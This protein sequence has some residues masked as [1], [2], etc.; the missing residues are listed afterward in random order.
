M[1]KGC[2]RFVLVMAASFLVA[3]VTLYFSVRAGLKVFAFSLP[4]I[5]EPCGMDEEELAEAIGDN[6]GQY[7]DVFLQAERMTDD[8][9]KCVN[10]VFL[11][12]VARL[13]SGN[14]KSR[15]ARNK[16]NFFG[17]KDRGGWKEFC[18]P[19]QCILFCGDR[20]KK[21]FIDKGAETIEAIGQTYCPDDGEWA[22]AVSDI[23][24]RGY[25]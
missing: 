22:E 21:R 20:I 9:E 15:L 19:E 7:A 3:A 25:K 6:L 11:A 8:G 13:E 2:L 5:T 24:R 4:K 16:N 10:A 18:S 14:G 12:A 17:W 1:N 23:Y